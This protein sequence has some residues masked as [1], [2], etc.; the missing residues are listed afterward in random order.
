MRRF[1]NEIIVLKKHNSVKRA[2]DL[3][4][5]LKKR[6]G[7][8]PM[9]K[10]VTLLLA[11]IM[12]FGMSI[13]AMA[14]EAPITLTIWHGASGES[15]KYLQTLADQYTET[16]P[17]VTIEMV[18]VEAGETTVQKMMAAAASNTTPN[19]LMLAWP[20]YIGPLKDVIRT[21]DDFIEQYPDQWDED[22]FLPSLLD[23]NC[24][25]EGVT[26]GT[27]IET[28]NLCLYYNKDLFE[29]AGVTP[30]TTWDELISTA[31]ALTDPSTKTW[32]LNLPLDISTLTWVWQCFLWQAGGEFA[33][34]EG[35]D[36]PFNS[37]A[38]REALQLF[39]DLIQTYEVAS[40]SPPQNG[41]ISGNVAMEITGPWMIPTYN[42]SETLNYGI[43]E[44]PAGPA[45][46]ATNIGG[47]V[48]IMMKSS[49]AGEK[50]S[51]DFLS[52]LMT[53]E[54]I[55]QFA[56]GYGTIP[57]RQSASEV[58]A[59]SN[60]LT[61]NPDIQAHIDSFEFGTYR[62]YHILSY[63]EISTIVATHLQAAMYGEETVEEALQKAY[64]ESMQVIET[65]I[66]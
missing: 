13:P 8:I 53:P 3:S 48:N 42:A 51:W 44:L 23:G 6:K 31:Q 36:L 49:E 64:D 39:V 2:C 5:T 28:N 16:N 24:R 55:S 26:Y 62:P 61:E 25:F 66:D 43:V 40:V 4:K 60:Y 11:L 54:I 10:L 30:P 47:T 19:I 15:A 59:W 1:Q 37:D 27:P 29:A 7:G 65:W 46:K 45:G 41:F 63:D 22:D 18:F 32:G 9:K 17:N 56:I 35:T 21:L 38:G 57:V 33:N 34:A 14:E 20:Q 50:A 52:W 58:E 12:A